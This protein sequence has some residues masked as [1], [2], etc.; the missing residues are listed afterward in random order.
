[1]SKIP[2]SKPRDIRQSAKDV[3]DAIAGDHEEVHPNNS[4][5][6]VRLWDDLSDRYAPPE[7]VKAMAEELINLRQVKQRQYA[8]RI[9]DRR[10]FSNPDPA[11]VIRLSD[12]IRNSSGCK[13]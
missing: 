7:V 2:L 3:L 9:I 6:M 12:E 5:E 1:M 13:K 10:R 11:L 8:Q 4:T